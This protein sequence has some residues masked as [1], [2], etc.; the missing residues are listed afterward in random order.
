MMAMAWPCVLF[1]QSKK[2]RRSSRQDFQMQKQVLLTFEV[3]N[4]HF[5]I[6][7]VSFVSVSKQKSFKDFIFSK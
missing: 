1:I 2:D 6:E 5:Y 3:S 4:N 7:Y